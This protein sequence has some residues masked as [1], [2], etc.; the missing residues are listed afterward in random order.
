M[1]C[2]VYEFILKN[3]SEGVE[4]VFEKNVLSMFALSKAINIQKPL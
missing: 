3:N 2:R 1:K 4:Y